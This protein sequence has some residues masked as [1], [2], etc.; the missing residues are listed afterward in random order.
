[1]P[2]KKHTDDDDDDKSLSPTTWSV[3]DF[4]G[5]ENPPVAVRRAKRSED[6]HPVHAC[7]TVLELTKLNND[8]AAPR[9]V[10][11][12]YAWIHPPSFGAIE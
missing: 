2:V 12:E 5:Q 4:P 9:H 6:P 7:G 1:M 10:R 8:E 3:L 11:R